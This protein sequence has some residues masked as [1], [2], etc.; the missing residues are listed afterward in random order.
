MFEYLIVERLLRKL[1]EN[2]AISKQQ[3]GF[4]KGNSTVHAMDVV[5][6]TVKNIKKHA[7]KHSKLC[8]LFTM[9]T[10]KRFQCRYS[11]NLKNTRVSDLINIIRV[12][13]IES[14]VIVYYRK[15]ELTGGAHQGFTLRPIL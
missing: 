14:Y 7:Y 15:A 3:F 13:L 9:D 11:R 12:Y 10:I 6:E 5:M 1:E 8:V 4:R 2:N